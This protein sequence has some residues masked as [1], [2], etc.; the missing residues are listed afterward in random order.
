MGAQLEVV[1][2][3]A[4][5]AEGV[6]QRGERGEF[7][8]DGEVESGELRESAAERVA[9]DHDAGG[10]VLRAQLRHGHEQRDG[11][12]VVRRDEALVEEAA[13]ARREGRVYVGEAHVVDPVGER[14]APPE[15]NDNHEARCIEPDVHLSKCY[16]N[17]L[18]QARGQ[19]VTKMQGGSRRHLHVVRV[20][21]DGP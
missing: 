8:V 19:S 1:V 9:G 11:D 4:R 12:A 15:R 18:G 17:T 21:L 13:G 6:E 10:V 2:A 14:L 5:G 16:N 7:V 3:D 20:A